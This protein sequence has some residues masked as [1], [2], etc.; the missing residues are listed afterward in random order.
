[1]AESI[2]RSRDLQH[3]QMELRSGRFLM[4]WREPSCE[5]PE[6]I[7]IECVEWIAA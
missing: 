3:C 1:M 2:C 6:A 5:V 4:G 7:S